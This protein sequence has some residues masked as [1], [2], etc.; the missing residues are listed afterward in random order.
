MRRFSAN[1]KI[2]KF[3]RE[4]QI[5]SKHRMFKKLADLIHPVHQRTF[6]N[7]NRMDVFPDGFGKVL[8]QVVTDALSQSIF[9]PVFHRT[10]TPGIVMPLCSVGSSL[11]HRAL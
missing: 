4:A 6:D 2:Q 10:V 5:L 8:L 11:F 1:L 7:G 3:E 9:Q